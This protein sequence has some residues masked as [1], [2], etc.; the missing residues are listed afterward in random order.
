M[1]FVVH[2]IGGCVISF[3]TG[4]RIAL[5]HVLVWA[6]LWLAGTVGPDW[7]RV[8]FDNRTWAFHL[9]FFIVVLVSY[10]KQFNF[11]TNWSFVLHV[12]YF[13]CDVSNPQGDSW[14]RL[15]HPLSFAAS[16]GV[17]GAFFMVS[18]FFG[19]G[20]PPEVMMQMKSSDAAQSEFPLSAWIGF[21]HASSV[22]HHIVDVVLS[23]KHF[24][25]IYAGTGQ[26]FIGFGL[27]SLW[28]IGQCYEVCY[29][30]TMDNYSAPKDYW[31]AVSH[32][33]AARLGIGSIEALK[34]RTATRFGLGEDFVFSWAVKVSGM[35][36]A[37]GALCW[38]KW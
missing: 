3:R 22:W 7:D 2:L 27:C 36:C 19:G 33:V 35:I 15:V 29:P 1:T 12:L 10:N 20:L 17:L 28:I 32:R 30:N 14:L 37:C 6:A 23:A 16:F 38:F 25:R 9:F 11:L 21:L 13:R 31:S 24:Q 34:S 18:K 4:I 5:C 8:A 26:W